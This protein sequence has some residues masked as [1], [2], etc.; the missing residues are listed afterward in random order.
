MFDSLLGKE[1]TATV[2]CSLDEL[3]YVLRNNR[4]REIIRI[5]ANID[6]ETVSKGELAEALA[7]A[8]GKDDPSSDQRKTYYVSLHQQHLPHLD[9]FGIIELRN[10]GNEMVRGRNFEGVVGALESLESHVK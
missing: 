2:N 6:Q 3:A 4:R 5:L 1:K 9:E 7:S 8:E 10:R